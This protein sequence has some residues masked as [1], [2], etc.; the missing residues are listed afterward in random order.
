MR[1]CFSIPKFLE[2]GIRY[3][4]HYSGGYEY[5][6]RRD[7]FS[8]SEI[9]G[10]ANQLSSKELLHYPV[11]AQVLRKS[12][13]YPTYTT[14]IDLKPYDNCFTILDMAN[15]LKH[16]DQTLE[17]ARGHKAALDRETNHL[18]ILHKDRPQI[19]IYN[20]KKEFYSQRCGNRSRS[21]NGTQVRISG[22]RYFFGWLEK[23]PVNDRIGKCSLF[24]LSEYELLKSY[25]NLLPYPQ[26]RL[27]TP[28]LQHISFVGGL[29]NTPILCF[30]CRRSYNHRGKIYY[31]D[32]QTDQ[33]YHKLSEAKTAANKYAK[34]WYSDIT[35][36]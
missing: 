6:Y 1:D 2:Q 19:P 30:R 7:S 26:N 14:R 17:A 8:I 33:L 34:N 12:Q 24:K 13:H 28:D 4:G 9:T 10:N 36:K 23:Y 31:F 32:L 29:I 18:L 35:K 21:C 25:R 15:N 20:G 16:L 3:S 5:D 11:L 27:A 22:V